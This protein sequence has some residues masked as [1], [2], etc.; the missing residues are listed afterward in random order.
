MSRALALEESIEDEQDAGIR[1]LQ[2]QELA[3]LYTQAG[4][5]DRAG[6]AQY[7][8]AEMVN[9]ADAWART[10]N[11]YFD[12]MV[13]LDGQERTNFA[14]KC[15][16][17]YLK[18]LDLDPT[19][20]SVR[21]DMGNAY[22]YDPDAPGEALR[23]T[24]IVLSMNPNHVIANFNR[25]IMLMN[26]GRSDEAIVQFEKVLTLAAPGDQLRQRTQQWLDSLR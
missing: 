15:I 10:G 12:W 4:R 24:E 5:L 1:Q 14:K 23:Q 21:T 25:G 17:A 6:D 3:N 18:S 2:L 13:Q 22:Q 19:N 9:T 26:A 8:L 16:D 7:T 20:L 11:S